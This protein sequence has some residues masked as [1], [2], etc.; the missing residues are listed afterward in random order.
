MGNR[1][2]ETLACPSRPAVKA[3]AKCIVRTP[4]GNRHMTLSARW[5]DARVT[6]P[7]LATGAPFVASRGVLRTGVRF[8][9]IRPLFCRANRSELVRR[10]AKIRCD[11]ALPGAALV[12]ASLAVASERSKGLRQNRSRPTLPTIFPV[13][14]SGTR[15]STSMAAS[16][17]ATGN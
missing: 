2:D 12:L 13:A 10:V 7:D 14:S 3:L 16:T 1:A 11:A 9:S 17:S 15:K 4:D 6:K 5:I 8:A